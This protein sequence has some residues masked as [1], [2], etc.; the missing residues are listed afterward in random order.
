MPLGGADDIGWNEAAPAETDDVG[1]GNEEIQSI[2][3]SFR[4]ATGSEHNWPSADADDVGYHLLGSGRA[5]FGTQSRISSSGTDGRFM[6]TSDTSRLAG[7]GSEGTML[8]GGA[9]ILLHGTLPGDLPQR[10]YWVMEAGLVATDGG[11]GAVSLT[12]PNSG[13]NGIPRLTLTAQRGAITGEGVKH[14]VAATFR[15]LTTTTVLI[16]TAYDG[17]AIGTNVHYISIGTRT[18]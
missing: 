13:F 11:T 12:F 6:V 16:D 10:D 15:E 3:T 9:T 17:G 14:N 18:F 7:A 2:R 5:Y 8:L 4:Q 1:D